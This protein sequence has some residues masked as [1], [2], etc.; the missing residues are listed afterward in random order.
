MFH[1]LKLFSAEVT[2]WEQFLSVFILME[3]FRGNFYYRNFML[4]SANTGDSVALINVHLLIECHCITV[5][6]LCISREIDSLFLFHQD[7][8]DIEFGVSSQAHAHTNMQE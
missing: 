2:D 5:T 1:L 8:Q 4:S 7:M 3:V 6:L